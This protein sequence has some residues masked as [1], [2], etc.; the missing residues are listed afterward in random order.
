MFEFLSCLYFYVFT[1]KS[2][3]KCVYDGLLCHC[4]MRDERLAFERFCTY[5]ENF[6]YS[7]IANFE[8][9][10]ILLKQ[11]FV[12]ILILCVIRKR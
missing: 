12:R 11:A 10:T 8:A 6:I 7:Y 4:A 3:A 5:T 9:V 2:E 1:I